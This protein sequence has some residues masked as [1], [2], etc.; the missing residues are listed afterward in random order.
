MKIQEDMP[1]SIWLEGPNLPGFWQEIH[2][3]NFL[4]CSSCAMIGHSWDFCRK[5]NKVADIPKEHF[6][7]KGAQ[8]LKK[9]D[10]QNNS[11]KQAKIKQFY[12]PTGRMVGQ[13]MEG[14]T[15]GAK[16]SNGNEIPSPQLHPA[17]DT[18]LTQSI[19]QVITHATTT[20]QAGVTSDNPFSVLEDL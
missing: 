9:T 13:I 10:T 19:Q 1:D 6:N 2:Y 7:T 20:E 11:W 8:Q 14:E 4:Y 5:R 17:S 3:P 15:S 18:L 16:D 12:K